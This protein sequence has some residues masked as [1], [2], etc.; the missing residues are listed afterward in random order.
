M[1]D[2]EYLI[3]FRLPQAHTK[4]YMAKPQKSITRKENGYDIKLTFAQK[5]FA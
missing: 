1:L 2:I 4:T 3:F 5:L